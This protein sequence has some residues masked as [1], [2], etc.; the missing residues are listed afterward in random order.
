[1][2]RYVGQEAVSQYLQTVIDTISLKFGNQD[3]ETFCGDREYDIVENLPD[4]IQFDPFQK[5]LSL[6]SDADADAGEY[7]FTLR[8]RLIY[9]FQVEKRQTFT[10]SIKLCKITVDSP[11]GHMGYT[12]G[13]EAKTGGSYEFLASQDCP[14]APTITVE[15]L[16]EFITHNEETSDFTISSTDD[17]DL[18]DTYSI[19]IRGTILIPDETDASNL[20][21]T[22]T[23]E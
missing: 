2:Q 4:F 15:G 23:E 19:I 8:V 11:T 10:V 12:L 20:P 3:G 16:P 21:L 13:D 14:S 9:F 22:I 1:M 17:L 7:T 5:E 6:K 18:I